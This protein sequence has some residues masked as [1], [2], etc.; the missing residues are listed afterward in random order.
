[1]PSPKRTQGRKLLIASIGIATVSY[2]GC[3]TDTNPPVSGNL[4][5][6]LSDGGKEGQGGS[7]ASSSSSSS[8]SGAS[9]SSGKP[10]TSGN[11]VPPPLLDA[12]AD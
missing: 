5:P 4:M 11:L 10:P 2:L 1:M 6:P 7:S 9:S 3:G 8:S 12:S